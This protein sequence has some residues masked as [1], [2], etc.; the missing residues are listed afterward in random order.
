V[1]AGW[2]SS[3]A[4]VVV[5]LLAS[6]LC[7]QRGAPTRS[8]NLGELVSQSAVILRGNVISARAEPHPDLT[9]LWTVVVTLQV[10]EVLKGEAGT[11]FTFRQFI[12]DIRDRYDAAGYR[13]G[14]DLLL[15][16][17]PPTPYGLSSPAGLE[18]GRFRIQRDRAGRETAVNGHGNSNL[19]RNLREQLE[20]K[21]VELTPPAARLIQRQPSGP[22]PLEGLR[23]AIQQ[24][25]SV[26][27]R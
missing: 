11:T 26:H 12:W 3:F 19:F 14:Q 18:Q 22:L 7:A 6:P 16:M 1:R 20:R 4:A 24:L 15:L 23:E 8:R 2:R 5:L 25:R 10:R 17:N 21:Q 9:N 13:K 27:L